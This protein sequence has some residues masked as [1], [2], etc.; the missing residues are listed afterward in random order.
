MQSCVV[1]LLKEMVRECGDHFNSYS[2]CIDRQ[3]SQEYMFER[4]RKEQH[5]MEGCRRKNKDDK[6][7][8][9]VD[10]TAK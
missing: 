10:S 3:I 6:K 2:E 4:C 5:N 8:S 7:E 1:D 9:Q